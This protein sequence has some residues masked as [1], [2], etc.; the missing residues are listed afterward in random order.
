MKN[1]F[2]KDISISLFTDISVAAL[3]LSILMILTRLLDIA[4]FAIW[5]LYL[6]A[7]SLLDM[8]RAGFIKTPL[9]HFIA[10]GKDADKMLQSA[11][12]LSIITAFIIIVFIQLLNLFID[13]KIKPVKPTAVTSFDY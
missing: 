13:M 6:S 4:T 9:V 7:A 2:T 12:V 11:I 10:S 5:T 3:S 1:I 8:V